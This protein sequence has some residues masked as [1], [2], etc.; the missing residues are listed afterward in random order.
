MKHEAVIKRFG[1]TILCSSQLKP[2]FESKK[3]EAKAAADDELDLFGDDDEDDQAAKEVQKKLKEEQEKKSK[4]K[5]VVIEKSLIL[6]EVKPLDD[7]IDLDQVAEKIMAEI[8][9][10]GLTWK[11]EYKKEPVAF[12]IFKLII[13]FV[14]EDLKVS[15]DND[16]VEN[17]ENMTESV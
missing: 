5:K 16:V 3:E 2:G 13:G 7:T 11:T 8:Q 9:Q 1:I 17:I 6:L 10:D 4:P 14:I 12:G 15:V